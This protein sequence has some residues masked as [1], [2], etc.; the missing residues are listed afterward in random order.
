MSKLTELQELM[1]VKILL[2][3]GAYG[4]EFQ[5]LELEED[6]YRGERFE[7]HSVPLQ[8]NHDIL[9]ITRPEVVKNVHSS[10]LE[11]GSDIIC[12]NTFNA[13]AISQADYDLQDICIEMNTVAAKIAREAADQYSCKDRPRFVAG[14]IG[15]TNRT[16]SLSPDVNQPG[17]RNIT[18]A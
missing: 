11:V 16:A 17:Y 13:N 5:A 8:G 15:P 6:D 7:S 1:Q 18:F 10:F 12:T 4:T 9:C 3:D 14:S 2:L